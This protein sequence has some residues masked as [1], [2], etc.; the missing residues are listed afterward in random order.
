MLPFELF[1]GLRYLRAKRRTGFLSLITVIS[2]L[3]IALGVAALIT[4]LSVMNGF[5]SELR[6]RILGITSHI[7]V[8]GYEGLE[9][10][11]E[12]VIRSA[13]EVEGVE[14]GAPYVREQGMLSRGGS[15]SGTIVRGVLPEWETRVSPTVRN[16]V[17]GNLQDLEAGSYGLVIGKALASNLSLDVGDQVTLVSPRG[18]VTPAGMLPRLKRFTVVGVFD[19][20][21]YEYNNGLVYGH[22]A[23]IRKLYR[24]GDTVSGIRLHLSVPMAAPEVAA[25]VRQRL[26]GGQF[27]RDWTQRNRNFFQALQTE[28]TAMFVILSLVVMVAAFNIVSSLVMLVNEKRGDIAILRTLG[29]SPGNIT[30]IFM[31]QGTVIGLFGVLLGT[32]AGVALAL[33]VEGFVSW[34]EQML[35]IQFLPADVYSVSRLPSRLEW[36]DVVGITL[37]GLIMSFLATIYPA[38]RAAKTDPVEALRYE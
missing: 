5:Q 34:L 2:A 27:V 32:L 36:V 1:I 37:G 38:R 20:G 29:A 21:M 12:G 10:P 19:A 23:D 22:M 6:D 15:V 18:Q 24:M 9:S 11:W 28:K 30:T 26:E 4:V 35:Q 7:T 3:G 25:E 16:L 17:R 33:N 8:T 13:E 14:G 31:L